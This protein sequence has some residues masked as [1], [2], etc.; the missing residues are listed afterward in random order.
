[1]S[2]IEFSVIQGGSSYISDP[3]HLT[4]LQLKRLLPIVLT[5]LGKSEEE[6]V[7]Q[8]DRW[9]ATLK[10]IQ[11]Q[12]AVETYQSSLKSDPSL[13]EDSTKMA[14]CSLSELNAEFERVCY[15]SEEG[16]GKT[17]VDSSTPISNDQ[18]LARIPMSKKEID[19]LI[20]TAD[21][22][23]LYYKNKLDNESRRECHKW[24]CVLE[25]AQRLQKENGQ[26]ATAATR[27]L[28]RTISFSSALSESTLTELC[29]KGNALVERLPEQRRFVL[30]MQNQIS[31]LP[32]KLEEIERIDSFIIRVE[33]ARESE[34]TMAA[35]ENGK[36]VLVGRSEDGQWF[37]SEQNN[38]PDPELK[39]LLDESIEHDP[40]LS[41]L[42]QY[43]SFKEQ[44]SILPV[45]QRIQHYLAHGTSAN[46]FL[47]DVQIHSLQN[48]LDP[49]TEIPKQRIAIK[50]FSTGWLEI[51]GDQPI[52]REWTDMQK[53]KEIENTMRSYGMLVDPSGI[54]A[55]VLP[56]FRGELGD[57]VKSCHGQDLCESIMPILCSIAKT[58]QDMH[59]VGFTH[60]DIKWSNILVQYEKV[61]GKTISTDFAIADLQNLSVAENEEVEVTGD[62]C[63]RQEL[64]AVNDISIITPEKDRQDLRERMDV[65]A[66]G[67]LMYKIFAGDELATPY[68]LET[69]AHL[70]N[71][72]MDSSKPYQQLPVTVP[73]SI[74][75]LLELML[76]TD[77]EKV[78]NMK[79]VN[80][81][82]SAIDLTKMGQQIA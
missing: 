57:Y 34:F 31:Q 52:R 24:K 45:E 80:G 49:N 77:S 37:I 71:L 65:R 55:I 47:L 23:Y 21:R 43:I 74:R 13:L 40:V 82:L 72:C 2:A 19:C 54:K 60:N 9:E 11:A 1:M 50:L 33:N 8:L 15:S 78:P 42:F 32:L 22:L 12:L 25:E 81:I 58:L 6:K 3:E 20:K 51:N 26:W 10:T 67:V 44:N 39:P 14:E 17:T 4:R 38:D 41:S 66:L 64:K 46:V 53:V 7:G 16:S 36:S 27:I 63:F 56:Y 79:D 48:V 68:P 70:M 30:Y 76:S 18:A 59:D 35:L 28:F 69:D 62:Y 75:I 73:L 5:I 61:N 29:E